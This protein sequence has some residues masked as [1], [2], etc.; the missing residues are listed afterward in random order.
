[1]AN[2]FSPAEFVNRY[3]KVKYAVGD[4]GDWLMTAKGNSLSH[5]EVPSEVLGP[6]G[7]RPKLRKA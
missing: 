1:M 7:K 2:L 5:V 3:Q 4:P 6:G